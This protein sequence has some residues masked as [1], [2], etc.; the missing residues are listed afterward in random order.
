M[1][2]HK[3]DFRPFLIGDNGDIVEEI[4]FEEYCMRVEKSCE[5][6]GVWGGEPEVS[7]RFS[8]VARNDFPST[9]RYICSN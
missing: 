3:D 9:Q 8:V 7:C 5:D 4:D 6:G 1:R 2:L